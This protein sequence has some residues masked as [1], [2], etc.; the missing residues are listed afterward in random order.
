MIMQRLFFIKIKSG[1]K[2]RFKCLTL[3][4]ILINRLKNSIGNRLSNSNFVLSYVPIENNM[5]H[6]PII[7]IIFKY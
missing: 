5:K 6:I 2:S 4:I 7:F 3:R 1:V